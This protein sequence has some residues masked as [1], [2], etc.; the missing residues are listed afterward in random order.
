[1]TRS[2]TEAQK[3]ASLWRARKGLIWIVTREEERVE[4]Y[5]L[6]AAAAAGFF[7]RTWDVAQGVERMDGKPDVDKFGNE[8]TLGGPDPGETLNLIKSR[9]QVDQDKPDN[10]KER[11][12]W[13]MRDL[14]VWLQGAPGA[15]VMRQLRN[16]SRLLPTTPQKTAQAIVVLSP[17][18]DVPAELA[19]HTT[20]IE[21]PLPD[22]DEI[23]KILDDI[24]EDYEIDLNGQREAAIDAAIGLSGEEA[25]SCYATSLVT[26]RTIDPV[27]V[28]K[29]KKN[30]IAATGALQWYDP[31]PDGLNSVGGMENLKAWLM[32]RSV[33][34]TPEARA[35]GLPRPRGT[36]LVGI[37]G[38]GKSLMCKAVSTAWQC[39]LIRVDLNALKGK[40]VGQSEANVRRLFELVNALGFCVLW[41]DEVEKAMAGATSASADGGVSADIMGSIL[42]WMQER[43]NDAF[44]IMT[45]NDVS[46]LPPEFLR[47]GRFDELFWVDLPNGRERV[48]VLSAALRS[49]GLKSDPENATV[50]VAEVAA[51][52][53][54]FTGSEIAAIVPDAMFMAYADKRRPISTEDLMAAVKTVVP[55]SVTAETKIKTMR[56]DAKGR[57]RPA[58][59]MDAD[60]VAP[61]KRSR[62][63]EMVS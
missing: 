44:V 40:F 22:R 6:E 57:F 32:G 11:G 12:V 54:G 36:L 3:I 48:E 47:K 20:V 7:P 23:A 14:P 46:A 8:I 34:Y 52:C 13:I 59:K 5:L 45:A 43:Q 42:T 58:S 53:E 16:L 2:Q 18:A 37:S 62:K 60:Q 25:Q 38:C 19:G 28:A 29:E 55:L 39:P 1:M 33:A 31:L 50:D 10:E 26:S 35:Y 21:W 9:S 17:S 63:V 56:E 4:G 41:F 30:V 61:Q 51:A 49:N 15:A 27:V 24:C